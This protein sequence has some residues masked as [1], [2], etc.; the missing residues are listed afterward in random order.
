[1]TTKGKN[2][3]S[4]ENAHHIFGSGDINNISVG[5][6]VSQRLHRYLLEADILRDKNTA[7]EGFLL[8]NVLYLQ[9]V[10]DVVE[11]IPE[12]TLGAYF[13]EVCG[14]ER[15]PYFRDFTRIWVDLVLKHLLGKIVN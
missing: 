7:K 5:I 12:D 14:C 2:K 3:K 6:I 10:L 11:R 9:A 4:E 1:M 15:A 13:R 8:A